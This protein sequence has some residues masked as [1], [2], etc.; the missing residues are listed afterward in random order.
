M[1]SRI[2][3][4]PVLQAE[5]DRDLVRRHWA[6]QAREKELL[7]AETKVYNNDRCVMKLSEL[8]LRSRKRSRDTDI[9][10]D[11]CVLHTQSHPARLRSRGRQAGSE[12]EAKGQES[13]VVNI[14]GYGALFHVGNHRPMTVS[15]V[16]SNI[17]ILV[18]RVQR[19]KRTARKR[20]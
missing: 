5:E 2:H 20:Y 12:I 3:L 6:E 8:R 13:H 18:K 16:H 1:W 4:I 14:A 11:S 19:G 15:N 10:A 7:G 9:G 17:D